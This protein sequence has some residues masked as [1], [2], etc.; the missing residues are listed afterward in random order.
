MNMWCQAGKIQ[1]IAH[2]L[3]EEKNFKIKTWQ[4]AH[5]SEAVAPKPVYMPP[6][7]RTQVAPSHMPE[8][9]LLQ[10]ACRD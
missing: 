10:G 5:P 9:R 6:V 3:T 2:G 1:E 8:L 7:H 4:A